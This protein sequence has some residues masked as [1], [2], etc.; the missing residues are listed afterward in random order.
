MAYSR[1]AHLIA[2]R[3]AT[4]SSAGHRIVGSGSRLDWGAVQG[5]GDQLGLR[6]RLRLELCANEV[7][8]AAH[9]CG[10]DH[11]DSYTGGRVNDTDSAD[12]LEVDDANERRKALVLEGNSHDVIESDMNGSE[13]VVNDKSTIGDP[14]AARSPQEVVTSGDEPNEDRHRYQ[15][16][17][18][19]CAEA[20]RTRANASAT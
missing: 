15:Q 8:S 11:L 3:P 9:A 19:G 10:S 14:D 20:R 5:R 1:A 17:A 4:T 12:S 16:C 2:S 7:S 18:D 13:M 6:S